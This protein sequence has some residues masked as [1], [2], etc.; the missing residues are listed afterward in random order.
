[1]IAVYGGAFDPIHIGHLSVIYTSLYYNDIKELHILPSYSHADK[2]NMSC[3]DKRVS[4]IKKVIKGEAD[5]LNKKDFDKIIVSTVEKYMPK[6]TGP[7]YTIDILDFYQ[8]LYPEE[9]IAF[10]TGSDNDIS[11][12]KDASKIRE[13]YKVIEAQVVLKNCHSSLIRE[14]DYELFKTY[15]PS[16]ITDE[17]YLF[18]KKQSHLTWL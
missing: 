17:T 12:Y 3:F 2:S 7:I 4:W 15:V 1:M 9:T 5:R 6:N 14:G 10:I 13:K 18:Y 11:K 8:T 16:I